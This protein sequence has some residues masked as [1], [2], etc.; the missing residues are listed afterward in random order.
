MSASG[1]TDILRQD[2][3]AFPGVQGIPNTERA[4]AIIQRVQNLAH[5]LRCNEFIRVGR[6][7]L[8]G[9]CPRAYL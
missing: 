9:H 5:L 7:V 6:H 3:T 8:G 4:E 1:N 2:V